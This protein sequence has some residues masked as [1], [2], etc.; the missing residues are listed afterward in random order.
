MILLAQLI[1]IEGNIY[2]HD[3]VYF[4]LQKM[5]M[6]DS[7]F[8]TSSLKIKSMSKIYNENKYMKINKVNSYKVKQLENG[9]INVSFCIDDSKKDEKF[10]AAIIFIERADDIK[11]TGEKMF[12]KFSTKAVVLL[13][14]GE[15]I[16][17]YNQKLF[18][19]NGEINFY[20]V[21]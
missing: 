2:C 11:T 7:F 4:D 20:Y 10:E 6:I 8:G 19:K 3:G 12:D 16:Q 17:L 5:S 9:F 18:V 13:K 21:F 14:E 1:I 15:E